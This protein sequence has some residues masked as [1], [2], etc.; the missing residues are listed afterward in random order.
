MINDDVIRELQKIGDVLVMVDAHLEAKDRMNA[1]LHMS[2]HVR[3][4]PLASAVA[5]ALSSLRA[6]ELRFTSA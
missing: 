4:T 6:L 2:E 3:S 5:G 1:A